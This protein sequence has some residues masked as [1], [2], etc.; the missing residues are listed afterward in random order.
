VPIRK[1]KTIEKEYER[2]NTYNA[3]VA[4]IHF[5]SHAYKNTCH[6]HIKN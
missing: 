2:K 6:K 5:F 1:A 3:M 4:L